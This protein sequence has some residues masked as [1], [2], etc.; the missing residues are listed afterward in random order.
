[1][2]I[3]FLILGTLLQHFSASI[4]YIGALIPAIILGYL[5]GN[6]AKNGALHGIIAGVIIVLISAI[7]LMIIGLSSGASAGLIAFGGVMLALIFILFMY[8]LCIGGS[9]GVS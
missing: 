5:V 9:I 3:L 6:G 7:I 1:M 8:W 2:G 4:G